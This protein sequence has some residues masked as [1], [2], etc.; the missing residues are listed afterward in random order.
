MEQLLDRVHLRDT[1]ATSRYVPGY[2]TRSS[3][4]RNAARYL[5]L[6]EV[7]LLL[8]VARVVVDEEVGVLADLP[9]DGEAVVVL[10][11]LAFQELLQLLA[12]RRR[13]VV[14]SM[15]RAGVAVACLRTLGRRLSL[16]PGQETIFALSHS[17]KARHSAKL[18]TLRRENLI[19]FLAFLERFGAV[20]FSEHI[21]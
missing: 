6:A 13:A 18:S 19:A 5:H 11:F 16:Q 9:A 21:C 15:R 7:V 12:S 14:T 17:A 1:H 2:L 3:S 10:E 20:Y 8:E 4:H